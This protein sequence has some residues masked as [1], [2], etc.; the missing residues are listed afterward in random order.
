[1]IA[2]M[3]TA[4]AERATR[5]HE[6]APFGLLPFLRREPFHHGASNG[7]LLIVVDVAAPL[8]GRAVGPE[9]CYVSYS[10]FSGTAD[11]TLDSWVRPSRLRAENIDPRAVSTGANLD[12]PIDG[13]SIYT[14]SICP[15]RK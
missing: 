6:I 8:Q 7:A 12:S 3:A 14:D 2:T 9:S 4:T 5:P 11:S 1:M 13:M 10:S 15:P